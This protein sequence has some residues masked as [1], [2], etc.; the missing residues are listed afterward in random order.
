[1]Q[2]SSA[3]GDV[4]ILEWRLTLTEQGACESIMLHWIVSLTGFVCI[5]AAYVLH[6]CSTLVLF[7]GGVELSL[8]GKALRLQEGLSLIGKE[9]CLG[10]ADGG[11]W[12]PTR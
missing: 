7:R 10:A 6:V 3:W 8:E 5:T 1:M 11:V 2:D 4:Q 9:G 12:A